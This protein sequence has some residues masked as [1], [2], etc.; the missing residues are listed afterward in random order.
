MLY[1]HDRSDATDPVAFTVVFGSE[2]CTF[3]NTVRIQATALHT[4]RGTGN[5]LRIIID[6]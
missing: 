4:E 2:A 1:C 5:L 3:S 6:R